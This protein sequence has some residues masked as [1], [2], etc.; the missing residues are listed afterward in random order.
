[1]HR[2]RKNIFHLM[3]G[4]VFETEGKKIFTMGGAYS[5][6]KYRRC[7]NIDWWKEEMPTDEEYKEA[8][9]NL[10][11]HGMSVDYIITHTAPTEVKRSMGYGNDMHE[12]ELS[13]FL[14]WIM[15]EVSF[16]KW[17]FGHFHIEEKIYEKF[18]ALY[19]DT[20]KAGED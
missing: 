5:I 12:A 1:M 13:G 4:Q 9:K 7:D 20:V 16:E 17:Y 15:H 6:D 3:R 8:A 19:Y 10:E 11:K 2:I 14:E 18:R